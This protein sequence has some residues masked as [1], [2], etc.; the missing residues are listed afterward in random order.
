R[1][2]ANVGVCSWARCRLEAR[3]ARHTSWQDHMHPD[4]LCHLCQH[5]ERV[6]SA[7]ITCCRLCSVPCSGAAREWSSDYEIVIG[8]MGS[9]PC[10]DRPQTWQSSMTPIGKTLA[11]SECHSIPLPVM[12][13]CHFVPCDLFKDRNIAEW[14]NMRT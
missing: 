11:N 1:N 7:R 12:M 5:C 14:R 8:E 4:R 10:F 9:A 6:S 13:S 2:Q 3:G